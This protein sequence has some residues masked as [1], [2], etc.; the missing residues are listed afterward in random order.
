MFSSDENMLKP[1]LPG[2]LLATPLQSNDKLLVEASSTTSICFQLGCQL[3]VF[4]IAT[5]AILALCITFFFSKTS[6][7]SK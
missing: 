5:R 4:K 7:E 3:Y 2:L 1:V 6:I